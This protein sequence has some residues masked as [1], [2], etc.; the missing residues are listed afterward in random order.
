[1]KKD[2]RIWIIEIMLFPIII[3]AIIFIL[4]L[5]VAIFITSIEYFINY[6]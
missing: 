4:W 6:F 1:M 5:F 2:N 3:F